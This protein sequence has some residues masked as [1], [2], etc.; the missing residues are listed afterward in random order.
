LIGYSKQKIKKGS[1]D[2]FQVFKKA[3]SSPAGFRKNLHPNSFKT[4]LISD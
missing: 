1:K 3:S 2:K 4:H